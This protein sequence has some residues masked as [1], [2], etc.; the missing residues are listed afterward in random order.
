[1]S[2][3]I[4]IIIMEVLT[5]MLNR[6]IAVGNIILHPKYKDPLIVSLMFAVD[7]IVFIKPTMSSIVCI[8]DVLNDF[9]MLNGLKVNLSKSTTL[10]TGISHQLCSDILNVTSLQNSQDSMSYLGIPLATTRISKV[11][12]C[13]CMSV[14]R[15][16]LTLGRIGSY[17]KLG[18]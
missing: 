18:D 17:P 13:L 9:Y 4:F 7:L 12:V 15:L 3:Y 1:M 11:N 8:V 5:Q 6:R 10:T 2:S 16:P 14:L